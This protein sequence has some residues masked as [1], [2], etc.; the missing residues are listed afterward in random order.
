MTSRRTRADVFPEQSAR[1][2][3][4]ARTE[5]GWRGLTEQPTPL[6]VRGVVIDFH[7]TYQLESGTCRLI[8]ATLE[9]HD[10]VRIGVARLPLAEALEA[11]SEALLGDARR[12]LHFSRYGGGT[13]RGLIWMDESLGRGEPRPW[14]RAYRIT[15]QA[16]W[17]KPQVEV[18]AMP[19]SLVKAALDVVQRL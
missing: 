8:E 9:I 13:R 10:S 12:G 15:T 3:P 14:S 17:S 2:T 6:T 19:E 4:I 16:R 7:R 11:P 1:R 5:L 18:E